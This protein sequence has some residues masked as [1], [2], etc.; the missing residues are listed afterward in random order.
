MPTLSDVVAPISLFVCNWYGMSHGPKSAHDENFESD[1]KLTT[2]HRTLTNS[3]RR[4][5][6]QEVIFELR[7][8]PKKT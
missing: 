7:T 4:C 1:Y 3:H 2:S 8:I 5:A 6:V